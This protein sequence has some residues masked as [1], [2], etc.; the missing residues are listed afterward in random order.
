VRA[1]TRCPTYTNRTI[2]DHHIPLCHDPPP[3]PLLCSDPAP[4]KSGVAGTGPSRFEPIAIEPTGEYTDAPTYLC[5]RCN[6]F[7]E[8][9]RIHTKHMCRH[10]HPSG[11]VGAFAIA[12][13]NRS[14]IRRRVGM[15]GSFQFYYCITCGKGDRSSLDRAGL[16]HGR[17]AG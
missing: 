8:S 2:P 13:R 17:V 16:Y 4:A 10:S 15:D 11:G 7:T 5:I 6:H 14:K 9:F 12:V 1:R 3:S